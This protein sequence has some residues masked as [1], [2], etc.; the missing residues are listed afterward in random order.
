M[1][2]IFDEAST[3]STDDGHVVVKGPDAVD[4]SVTPEA[5]VETANRLLDHA[6]EAEGHR[7]LAEEAGD[8][9]SPDKD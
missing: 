7:M 6:A 4:I 5:A 9:T 1:A 8:R 3:V 2:E